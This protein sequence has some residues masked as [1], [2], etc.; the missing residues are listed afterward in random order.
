MP[1]LQKDLQKILQEKFPNG[2]IQIVDLA[3]DDDHYSVTIIDEIFAG[4]TR[5]MQHKMVN[6]ALGDVIKK[7]LHAM[8][9][10]TIAK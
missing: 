4:K 2:E 6:E 9:L 10:K 8:Q 5:I 1:I 7:Q 3:G